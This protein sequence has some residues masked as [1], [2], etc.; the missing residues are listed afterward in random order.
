M[1]RAAEGSASKLPLVDS[2][3]HLDMAQFDADREAVVGR[4]RV[5]G[6]TNLLIVG[7]V[8]AER[9]H[10]RALDVAGKLGFP[11]SAGVHPHEARLA[12]EA[13]YDELGGLARDGRI[14]AIGEIGL[15]FHYDHSPRDVQREVFRRQLH[16]A[17]ELGRPVIIHTREAD[18]ETAALLEEEGAGEVG[19]VIHCFTGGHELARR[20]LGLGFFLSFSG[21]VAFPRAEVI[22]EVAR[23]LP[24]DR[25]LIETDSP[26]LAPPPHRGKRNEPAYVLE[27]ARKVA[28][29]R[30]QPV[31]EVG[32]AS[33]ENFRRLFRV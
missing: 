20:A 29:L 30:Q 14:V 6:V 3:C 12:S 17:R 21:I 5:A 19:G 25:L 4:A 32:R 23:T 27:V 10:R 18:E 24:L 11:A 15:D 16:L 2:H 9:G 8:D 33:Q 13:I 7:G 31:E 22:Q 26:F 28:A 1:N